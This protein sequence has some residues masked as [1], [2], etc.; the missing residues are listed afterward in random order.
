MFSA[1]RV[2]AVI[3]LVVLGSGLVLYGAVVG[4]GERQVGAPGAEATIEPGQWAFFDG[5]LSLA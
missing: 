5:T 4:P 2:A 1:T 3:T